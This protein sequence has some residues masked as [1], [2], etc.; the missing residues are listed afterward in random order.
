MTDLRSMIFVESVFFLSFLSCFY[1]IFNIGM[2]TKINLFPLNKNSSSKY[3]PFFV[4]VNTDKPRGISRAFFYI[5]SVNAM[6]NISK[7]FYFIIKSV[8]I[9]VINFM[10]W[11]VAKNKKPHK[12]MDKIIFTSKCKNSIILFTS[13]IIYRTGFFIGK[14]GIKTFMRSICIKMIPRA[15]PPTESATI[16]AITKNFFNVFIGNFHN[17]SFAG[18]R[19]LYTQK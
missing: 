6:L 9:Y 14:S 13:E 7:V 3:F 18:Q 16:R 10:L 1:C 4:K 8:T 12:P 2:P 5:F 15:N 11:P 19:S 17:I